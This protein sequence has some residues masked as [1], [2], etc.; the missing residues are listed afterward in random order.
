MKS[1]ILVETSHF[2]QIE[3]TLSKG[4][5]AEQEA[6]SIDQT[7]FILNGVG[8]IKTSKTIHQIHCRSFVHIPPDTPFKISNIGEALLSVILTQGK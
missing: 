5:V 1:R 2:S 4:E 7:F 3:L 6:F 8:V